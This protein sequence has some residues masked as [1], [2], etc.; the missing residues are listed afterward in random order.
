MIG[1]KIILFLI[2]VLLSFLLGVV[3]F[4]LTLELI[5]YLIPA[6][7]SDGIHGVMPIGQAMISIFIAIA[8][9]ILALI[10]IYKKMK[11]RIIN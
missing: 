1:K 6:V 3:I 4:F 2:S 11:R 9:G 5:L 8:G 7:A 10:F